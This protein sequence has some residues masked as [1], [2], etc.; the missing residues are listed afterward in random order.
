MELDA[1][2]AAQGTEDTLTA[3][4][5]HGSGTLTRGT[6]VGRF[7]LLE[8]LGAGAMGVVYAAYSVRGG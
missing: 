6:A 7:L 2:L 8:R 1:T 5:S 3:T 4:T